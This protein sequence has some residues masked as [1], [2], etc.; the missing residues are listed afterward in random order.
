MSSYPP[1]SPHHH[2]YPQRGAQ[3]VLAPLPANPAPPVGVGP[4]LRRFGQPGIGAAV[5]L[6]VLGLLL[7]V[8]IGVI[9]ANI[10]VAA[11]PVAGLLALLPL[12]GVM[13][14]VLWVDRWE[15]EPWQAI[16]VAFGWGASVSVLVA[17]VLNTGAQMVLY[18]V[19]TQEAADIVGAA[20]VAPVVEESIKALGV[21]L[22]FLAWRRTFDGPVD[23][24]VYAATVAAGFAFVE[25]ILYFGATMA[26]TAGTEA[27][28]P[29]VATVF[30]LRAVMSPFA[31]LL[32][33]ACTGLALGLAARSRSRHAWLWAFPLGLTFA[34]ILHGL[35]NGSAMMNSESGFF[36]L[37]GVFQVPLF[38]GAVGLAFWLR[39]Q[40]AKVVRT[41]L[42]E[43]AASGWFA[44][45]EVVM[46][47]SLRERRRARAWAAQHGGPGGRR[48]MKA[49]QLAATRLAYQ[50]HRLL[51]QRVDHR[52]I[53]DEG[54]LLGEVNVARAGLMASLAR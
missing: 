22:I 46:L 12:A 27:A 1:P 3:A 30:V 49:F 5:A 42:G 41:R 9:A 24:L 39:R 38:L 21:L 4:P 6:V 19:G 18:A 32:F 45:P 25:N 29:A 8:A 44:P 51:T 7:L 33:T 53:A 28:G 52:S 10:G 31:H 23:G 37:Y 40:E 13:A 20:V 54:Q 36:V 16:A 34:M 50:R 14:A 17:L 43:Y 47:A 48:A 2:P 35:W 11:L 26:E 15:R